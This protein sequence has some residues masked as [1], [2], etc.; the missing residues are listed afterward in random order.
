MDDYDT[1]QPPKDTSWK[2]VLNPYEGV[3]GNYGA[4]MVPTVYGTVGPSTLGGVTAPSSVYGRTAGP[5]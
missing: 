1:F 5:S 2:D 3:P 4:Y